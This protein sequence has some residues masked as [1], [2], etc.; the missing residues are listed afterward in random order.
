VTDIPTL[1]KQIGMQ[2]T[3]LGECIR[4]INQLTSDLHHS[5][6]EVE[7]LTAEVER[8]RAELEKKL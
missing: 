8:L 6:K 5:Q 4:K 2:A 3:R 1:K 7:R